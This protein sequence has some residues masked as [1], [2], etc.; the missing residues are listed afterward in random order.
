MDMERLKEI[1]EIIKSIA[2][3]M[4]SNY[5]RESEESLLRIWEWSISISGII[6][7]SMPI[8]FDRYKKGKIMDI[9]EF[10]LRAISGISHLD[11]LLV[12]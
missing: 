10:H 8:D 7:S 4:D 1:V 9:L 12:L 2:D 11:S 6:E 3:D 5:P